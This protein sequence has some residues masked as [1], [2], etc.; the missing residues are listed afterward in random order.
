MKD[1]EKSRGQ[2]R[3]NYMKDPEKSCAD[4]AAK[5]RESYMKDPEMGC[6]DII[7]S[8]P[9]VGYTIYADIVSRGQTT[10]F[11]QGHYHFQYKCPSSVF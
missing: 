4:S 8:I 3:E 6:A 5:S 1:P 10:I 2:S 9:Y 11:A 7:D